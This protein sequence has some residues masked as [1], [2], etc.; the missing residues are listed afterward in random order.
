MFIFSLFPSII[1]VCLCVSSCFSIVSYPVLLRS[2]Y[3]TFIFLLFSVKLLPL[4]YILHPLISVL[5]SFFFCSFWVYLFIFFF[6][7]Y[8]CLSFFLCLRVFIFLYVSLCVNFFVSLWVYLFSVS[9]CVYFSLFVFVFVFLFL[10][11]FFCFFACSSFSVC[12][13]VHLLFSFS[14][15]V[16]VTS[17]VRAEPI[18]DW[19]QPTPKK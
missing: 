16:E 3:R 4:F 7:F 17:V 19:S 9:L 6:C 18:V 5:R 2:V 8:V 12:S 15:F 11:Y 14:L 10:F 13:F 1:L